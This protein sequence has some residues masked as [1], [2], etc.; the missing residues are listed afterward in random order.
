MNTLKFIFIV[1]LEICFLN[2]VNGM[3][4]SPNKTLSIKKQSKIAGLQA[5]AKNKPINFPSKKNVIGK[6]Q[7]K[8]VGLQTITQHRSF[9]NSIKP[10]Y[11]A[12]ETID[13]NING[14]CNL[15]CKW[16]WGPAHNAK[17]DITLREWKNLA[18]NLKKLGTKSIV[19]TGGETLLKK[20]LPELARYIKAELGLRTTLSSNGLLL[21]KRGPSIL[22]FIDDLGLP[23]DGHSI[24]VNSSMRKGTI[25]H[26]SKVLEAIRFT[27][28]NFENIKLTVRT[29][30]ASPNIESLH[31]IGRTML[32]AGIDPKKMRWKI[33]QVSPI[34]PRKDVILNSDLLITKKHFEE[35]IEKSKLI[36]PLFTI[37]SQPYENSFGR[38]FHIFPDG[39][40]HIVIQGKDNFPEELPM[41]NIIKDFDAVIKNVNKQFNFDINHKHGDNN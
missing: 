40:S 7:S 4:F 36:N 18:S 37:E 29:V 13:F 8:I 39:K 27:Q 3:S 30:A 33:Y 19:F 41:G 1:L 17:E 20:D 16:C 26:F 5:I 21:V 35:A 32:E 12:P 28:N 38:Y 22:P 31:L 15:D 34:G 25:L 11:R 6:S 14:I 10:S 23:L 2:N 9:C 24:E